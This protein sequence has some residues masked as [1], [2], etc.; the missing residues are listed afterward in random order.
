MKSNRI[1]KIL[2]PDAVI[3]W[4]RSKRAHEGIGPFR[5]TSGHPRDIKKDIREKYGH[6][7]ELLDL[8][9]D[10]KGALVHKWHHYIP[11]YDRYF[12]TFRGRKIKFLENGVNNG[13]SLQMLRKYYGDDAIIYGID[14]NPKCEKLNYIA[15]QVRI[16]SQS[17]D[18]FLKS[19][20]EEMRGVDIIL[21]DGSHHMIH[22][23]ATLK[24]LFP[25]LSCGGIYMIEDLHVAYW[26]RY[27]GGYR[28]KNNFLRLPWM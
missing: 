2:V 12:S 4:H 8:F 19:V 15:G 10:N 21:D 14:I 18:E 20:I 27:G 5:F 24:Y 16:G 22:I 26:K 25:H 6:E 17:G 23:P 13:G 7:S 9:A 11:L 1:A 28:A 3:N